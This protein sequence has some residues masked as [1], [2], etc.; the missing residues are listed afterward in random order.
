MRMEFASDICW[1]RA[2]AVASPGFLSGC[3]RAGAVAR[4]ERWGR[5]RRRGGE[6]RR[7]SEAGARTHH[8]MAS[9]R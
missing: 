5:R 7:A 8:F 1:K 2:D 9:R 3:L 4:G 6:E